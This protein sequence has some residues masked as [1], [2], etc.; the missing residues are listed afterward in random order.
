MK[1]I[2][3]KIWALLPIAVAI[4]V[5]MGWACAF[6]SIYLDSLGTVLVG[7]LAGP[8][9]GALAGG[10]SNLVA[11]L[12]SPVWLRYF[13][14]A[15]LIGVIAGWMSSLGIM[16]RGYLAAFGGLAL[17]VLTACAAAP[18]TA[19]CGGASGSGTDLAIA[20]FRSF[21]FSS[22]EACFAGA[23]CVD[24]LDKLASVLIVQ[25]ALA[26]LPRQLLLSFPLGS[27]LINSRSWFSE[28]WKNSGQ[29]GSDHG[30]RE[31]IG[32]VECATDHPE[33]GQS[34]FHRVS[35]ATKLTLV[36]CCCVSI[37]F[38]PAYWLVIQHDTYGA[39]P[40]WYP[41]PYYPI[42]LALLFALAASAGIG[43]AM[44]RLLMVSAVPLGTIIILF[45]GFWGR[46]GAT[47]VVG[48][49]LWSIGG[50]F[51]GFERACNIAL[52]VE[53]L[54]LLFLTTPWPVLVEFLESLGLPSKLGY[55]LTASLNFVPSMRYQIAQIRQAQAARALPQG[56]SMRARLRYLLA[57]ALPLLLMAISEANERALALEMRGFGASKKRTVWKKVQHPRYDSDLQ[58]LIILA[59][60]YL[61]WCCWQ[62]QKG[63]H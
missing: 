54:G 60:L 49:L 28:W 15:V 46:D 59:F 9:A 26:A 57:V 21:G 20:A 36:F 25:L 7:V 48:S 17:G 33:N 37:Y 11:S 56:S 61:A 30:H 63:A 62:L 35:P 41:L 18:I 1:K 3:T 34:W 16:R 29:R 27:K 52:I 42:M 2:D 53:S 23:L 5:T 50:A 4:N 12:Q 55:V 38:V 32:V 31:E 58:I 24:P 43:S 8:W 39:A 6:L 45:N 13:P 44:G 40:Y 19:W 22:L 10:V 47:P 51:D 14:V